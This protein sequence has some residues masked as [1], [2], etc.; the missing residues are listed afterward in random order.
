[1]LWFDGSRY[2]SSFFSVLHDFSLCK[3]LY[4][5]RLVARACGTTGLSPR[6]SCAAPIGCSHGENH[7]IACKRFEIPRVRNCLSYFF[8]SPCSC[9]FISKRI[10]EVVVIY[11]L[12]KKKSRYISV[13]CTEGLWCCNQSTENMGEGEN[14]QNSDDGEKCRTR[15]KR[16]RERKRQNDE[17]RT[18]WM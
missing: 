17:E 7:R 11:A 10:L 9:Y 3:G 5:K 13:Y 4:K 6:G 1:M 12:S 2:L 14:K 16:K 8:L 15:E 18:R